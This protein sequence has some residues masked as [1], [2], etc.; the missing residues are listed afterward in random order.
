MKNKSLKIPAIII[1]IGLVLSLA[2]Y[3]LTG[4]IKK[5]VIT[6]HD[7]H[8]AATYK[9]DG[10][11]KTIEGIYRVRFEFTGEGTEPL[12]RYYE[13]FYLSEPTAGKPEF[14]TISKKDDLEL[15]IVFI[16]TD[17]YLMGDGGPG[18][19]YSDAITEPYLAVYDREGYEY[20]DSEMLGKFDAELLSWEIPQPIE[21]TFVFSGF[22][23]LHDGSMLSMLLVGIL[24]IVACMIFVKRDKAVPYKVLD[25]VSVVLNFLVGFVAVPFITAVAY[26]M[27]IYASGDEIIYQIDRCVPAIAVFGIAAS[28]SLRRKG[29]TRTGFLIQFIGPVLFVILANLEPVI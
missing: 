26:L 27:G 24:V 8:Y 15:C 18:E 23:R 28:L 4:I 5:P 25:K 16:F 19:E 11:T 7:F 1:A 2:A 14:H 29:F 17:D 22:S 10:E 13:G 3:L 9:L 12:E 6:E 20:S 21:N